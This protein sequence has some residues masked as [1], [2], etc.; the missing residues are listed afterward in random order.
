MTSLCCYGNSDLD[1]VH[2]AL[3]L[4]S[5]PGTSVD[6]N[7]LFYVLVGSQR[8]NLHVKLEGVAIEKSN[9]ASLKQLVL[10]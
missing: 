8:F 2:S 6:I 1:K 5:I 9:R 3:K 10:G 4:W 7:L